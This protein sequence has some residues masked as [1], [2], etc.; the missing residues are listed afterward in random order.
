MTVDCDDTGVFCEGSFGVAPDIRPLGS[1]KPT[2][3]QDEVR[4]GFMSR[5]IVSKNVTDRNG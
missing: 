4:M 1:L 3:V 5:K 2:S